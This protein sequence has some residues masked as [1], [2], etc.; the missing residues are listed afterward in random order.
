MLDGHVREN[1]RG[2]E[3]HGRADFVAC[4]TQGPFEFPSS[5]ADCQNGTFGAA[6]HLMGEGPRHVRRHSWRRCSVC[7]HDDQINSVHRRGVQDPFWEE[8]RSGHTCW[9]RHQIRVGWDQFRQSSHTLVSR[10]SLPCSKFF[11]SVI[12]MVGIMCRS[13]SFA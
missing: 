10:R 1:Q 6:D 5:I 3:S 8:I 13:T 12:G 7:A 11:S 4:I 9:L 2:D